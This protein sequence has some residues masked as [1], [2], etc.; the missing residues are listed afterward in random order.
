MAEREGERQAEGSGR[1]FPIRTGLFFQDSG[2]GDS[3]V[4]GELSLEVSPVRK[5]TAN[6]KAGHPRDYGAL[7]QMS[8]R[9]QLP[10]GLRQY[11]STLHPRSRICTEC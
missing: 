4:E 7:P 6:G 9:K 8:A 10:A 1:L 5:Q 11:H 2:L 3:A